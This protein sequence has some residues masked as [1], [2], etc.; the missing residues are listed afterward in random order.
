MHPK[1]RKA[2]NTFLVKYKIRWFFI[3]LLISSLQ[4]LNITQAFL[5]FFIDLIYYIHIMLELKRY[6]IY[7]KWFFKVKCITQETAILFFLTVL[8][9]FGSTKH[10]NFS[11]TIYAEYLEKA[12]FGAVILA[13][14]AEIISMVGLAVTKTIE[15]LKGLKQTKLKKKEVAESKARSVES[16]Q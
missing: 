3:F 13:I 4:L 6:T 12:V 9:I 2:G 14:F 1:T 16:E 7:E 5:I 15:F 8:F 10:T 11:E